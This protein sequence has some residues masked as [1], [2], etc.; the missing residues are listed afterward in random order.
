MGWRVI[1]TQDFPFAL[2]MSKGR[3]VSQEGQGLT[4]G[5][6]RPDKLSPNGVGGKF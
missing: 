6:L 3:T 1:M 2:S 4:F 5:R